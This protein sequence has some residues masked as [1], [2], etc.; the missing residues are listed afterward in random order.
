MSEPKKTLDV[1]RDAARE[2]GGGEGCAAFVA[3]LLIAAGWAV[4]W[5]MGWL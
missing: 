2:V 4:A 1:Y 5:W 3:L